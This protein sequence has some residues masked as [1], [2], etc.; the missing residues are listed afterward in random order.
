MTIHMR[1][2]KLRP[3]ILLVLIVALLT[4]SDAQGEIVAAQHL[5][6]P[7]TNG[8]FHTGAGISDDN[9]AIFDNREMQTFLAMNGGNVDQ[10][11]FTAHQSRNTSA[12]LRID[13]V[14]LVNDQPG[15]SLGHALVPINE[16]PTTDVYP[17]VLNMTADF[18]PASTILTAG[19]RYGLVFSSESPNANYRLY[20]VSEY[21]LSPAARYTAG[22]ETDSQNGRPYS[23]S[24]IESDLYFKIT[25]TPVPEPS[26]LVLAGMGCVAIAVFA[27]KRSRAAKVS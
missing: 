10:V 19:M 25:V 8:G 13:I 17:A 4:M 21:Q 1:L 23:G 27:R 15:T 26:S 14:T 9:G 12:P 20:G 6:L 2:F 22:R 18:G 11:S 5:P 3:S 24:S 16:F 7:T